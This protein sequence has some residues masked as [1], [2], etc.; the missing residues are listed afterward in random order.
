MSK[1]IKRCQFSYIWSKPSHFCKNGFTVISVCLFL[2][3]KW[4]KFGFKFE[5]FEIFICITVI[6]IIRFVSFW[7]EFV[8]ITKSIKFVSGVFYIYFFKYKNTIKVS[9][10][11]IL[12][13][14]FFKTTFTLKRRRKTDRILLKKHLLNY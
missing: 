2:P 8:S 13:L 12:L 7:R 1:V 14:N 10:I 3:E 9:L 5:I 4:G 11:S 6:F